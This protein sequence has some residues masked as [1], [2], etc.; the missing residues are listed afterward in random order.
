MLR[1]RQSVARSDSL[2][3]RRGAEASFIGV[4]PTLVIAG[5]GGWLLSV[6]MSARPRPPGWSEPLGGRVQTLHSGWPAGAG[7]AGVCCVVRLP[8]D[9]QCTYS[10]LTVP[11]EEELMLHLQ[12]AD[13]TPLPAPSLPLVVAQARY[14]GVRR[15]VSAEVVKGVQARLRSAAGVSLDR[16]AEVTST[17]I[18]I[19][20][21][22]AAPSQASQTGVQ[23][24]TSDGRWQA[25]VTADWVSLET[26]SFH[27]YA[28]EFAPLLG[29]LLAA[30]AELLEPVTVTRAGLRFVNMLRPPQGDATVSG[31]GTPM[32]WGRWIRGSLVGPASDEWLRAGVLSYTQQVLLEVEITARAAASTAAT[33][34]PLRCG[35]RSGPVDEQASAFLLDIDNFAEPQSVWETANVLGLFED[36]NECGA[37]LFQQLVT[38]EMLNHLRG[39]TSGGSA[40]SGTRTDITTGEEQR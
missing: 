5:T 12:P 27:S 29:E 34:T 20:P 8:R 9:R 1:P 23:L 7:H 36:L 19:S 26:Q 22:V 35:V 15:D 14:T 39:E 40:T 13:H 21:G 11:T 10:T 33:G 28:N 31:A 25:T 3:R 18:V 17:D 24:T 2:G 32:A 6:A 37:A 38:E 16:V 30:V 4:R